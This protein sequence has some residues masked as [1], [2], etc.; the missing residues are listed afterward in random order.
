MLTSRLTVAALSQRERIKA[1]G[2]GAI[3]VM[4]LDD[5]FGSSGP[6]ASHAVLTGP[7]ECLDILGRSMAARIMDRFVAAD[8]E[9]VHLLAPKDCS[10]ANPLLSSLENA[11]VQMVMDLSPEVYQV[12]IDQKLRDY[13]QRG[14]E[15]AFVASS[16]LYAETDLLDFFYFHREARQPVT[17]AFDR[18]GPL[19]LWV[20]DTTRTQ[21]ADIQKLLAKAEASGPSYFIREY[22]NRLTHP[23]N[24]RRFACDVLR[25]RCAVRP[26]GREIKRGIWI[27]EGAEVHRRAR[28]VAPAYIGRA[29]KVMQDTLVTRSSNI[30]KDCCVDYGTVIENSSILENTHVGICLDV[31]HAVANRNHLLSLGRNVVVEISDPSIM[32][33]NGT[34]WSPESTKA[35]RRA[36]NGLLF[37]R[38]KKKQQVA[39]SQPAGSAPEPC[40]LQANPIQG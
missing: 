10:T 18:D 19:D 40:R 27:D 26:P 38:R 15:H 2:I 29:S 14:I 36:K 35:L 5:T 23:G 37:S 28:I 22:V 17:R 30:E 9:V 21:R 11:E 20:V 6:H 31:C 39:D 12:A 8:A 24:L 1:V 3:V 34:A 33:A 16:A 4:G 13:S 32:R 7:A 25:G